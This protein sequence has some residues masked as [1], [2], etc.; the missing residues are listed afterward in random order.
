[1]IV[2]IVGKEEKRGE[3]RSGLKVKV[4]NKGRKNTITPRVVIKYR[5]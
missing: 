2:N 1:M 4:Y 3:Q 5:R